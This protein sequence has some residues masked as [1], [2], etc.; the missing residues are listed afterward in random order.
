MKRNILLTVICALTFTGIQ[1]QTQRLPKAITLKM[2]KPSDSS[3][4]RLTRHASSLLPT[5]TRWVSRCTAKAKK[6]ATSCARKSHRGHGIRTTPPILPLLPT[7]I[8]RSH[9][10]TIGTAAPSW[11]KTT[12]DGV[13][14]SRISI[15]E[16]T[17]PMK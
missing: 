6:A 1:A 7:R 5:T 15:Q 9:K 17:R 11:H 12:K 4:T 13:W 3:K 8:Y 2:G 16:Q 10:T 14:S